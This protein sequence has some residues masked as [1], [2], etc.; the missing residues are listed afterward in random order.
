MIVE[1]PRVGIVMST[2]RE[3]RKPARWISGMASGRT[4]LDFE[5]VHLRNHPRVTEPG[6]RRRDEVSVPTERP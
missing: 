6:R 2:T 5:I 1:K 4:D 3:G